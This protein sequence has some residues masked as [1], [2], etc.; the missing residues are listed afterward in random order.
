MCGICGFITK[1]NISKDALKAMNDTMYHRGPDDS[2]EELYEGKNGYNVGFAQRR[3][4][5]LDLSPLGHQPMHSPD[6]RISLVYNGEIYNYREVR[7]ELKDYTFKSNC[8]TEVIIASYLKWGIDC[9]ERF[10]GM[11]AIALYD[12]DENA[13]YLVRDRIGKKPLYYELESGPDGRNIYFS[14]ELKP[15]MA[16]PGFN[17]DINTKVISRFLYQQYIN[18]P[19]T[20]FNNVYKL[21]P[22]AVLR[23]DLVKTGDDEIKIWKYWDI[24]TVYHKMRKDPVT[25][26][27]EGK[28]ELKNLLREAV[29]KRMIS[30]VPL[31]TFLSGGYDSSLTTAIAQELSGERVKTFSIGFNEEE[32]NEAK[33]AS[34]VAKYLG[35]DHTERYISENEMYDLVHSIPKYYDEPF[36]DSSE[37]CTML[38]SEVAKEKVTVAISGDGGDEFFCGYNIYDNVKQAKAL[39]V[40]GAMTYGVCNAPGFK[41]AGMLDKLPL[42]VKVVAS[43]RNKETKTQIGS[44]DYVDIAM[45]MVAD[46]SGLPC[47]YEIESKY[48]ESNWQA[49]RML[50]D[51]D[52]YLPGDILAKVDRA[53]MK[54]S[55][56]SR[57]PI[58]DKDVMEYSFRLDHSFKYSHG[59]KKHILKDI[60]YDYIPKELLERPKVGFGVPLDKWLRGP[61]KEELLSM[62]DESFLKR[63]G[64]FDAAYVSKMVNDY[65]LKG[66]AGKA[67]GRNYS[68]VVWPFFVFEQWY[69]YYYEG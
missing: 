55:L 44:T 28:A 20:V 11:F 18:A 54:Y 33:Y 2:G 59:D 50:L 26:Y 65:V 68:K 9:I 64:I 46:K 32:Y 16:R 1:N 31:G 36:A 17:K 8:D 7:E 69:R 62:C 12:R 57:C 25:D 27:A 52:C 14:S 21:E 22:G 47:R 42:R 5:I 35:T 40:L 49:R 63:Q 58:L 41:Q 61:L 34:E 19:E 66:D 30:D 53:S 24:N 38:V 13:L 56:E 48:N 60:A 3:L 29:R 45:N 4:S 6:G 10:N 67:T 43:N 37:I 23:F 39:D 51:M 15:L